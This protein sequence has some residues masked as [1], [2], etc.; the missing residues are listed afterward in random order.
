VTLILL[1][2]FMLV[3]G[4]VL[5]LNPTWITGEFYELTISSIQ[6]DQSGSVSLTYQDRISYGTFVSWEHEKTDQRDIVRRW[7]DG[8]PRL[9]RFTSE[10]RMESCRESLL[11]TAEADS[12]FLGTPALRSRFQ[13]EPGTYRMR[14]GEKIVL[15]KGTLPDGST[16]ETRIR[17]DGDRNPTPILRLSPEPRRTSW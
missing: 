11:T 13:L 6:F 10:N 14:R 8:K 4:G 16:A 3:V 12:G 15:V 17:L 1:L 9:L 2:A 7:N 5:L